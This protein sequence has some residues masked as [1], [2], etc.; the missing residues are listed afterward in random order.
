[1]EKGNKTIQIFNSYLVGWLSLAGFAYGIGN[2]HGTVYFEFILTDDL[3]LEIKK[4]QQSPL[5]HYV[6][7]LKR[8]RGLIRAY[9]DQ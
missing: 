5:S 8:I 2:N 7:E 9:R 4:F 6:D 1:M 3:M